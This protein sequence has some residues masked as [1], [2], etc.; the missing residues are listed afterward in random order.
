MNSRVEVMPEDLVANAVRSAHL[1][2]GWSNVELPDRKATIFI[3][4]SSDKG[5]L[6]EWM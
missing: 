2:V 1:C 5:I 6:G 3:R 4:S